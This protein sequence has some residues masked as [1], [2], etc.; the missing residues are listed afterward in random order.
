MEEERIRQQGT[1]TFEIEES[2]SCQRRAVAM[3][4]DGKIRAKRKKTAET[5]T[6]MNQISLATTTSTTWMIFVAS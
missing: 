6:P 5:T 3:V 1:T 4:G 2:P